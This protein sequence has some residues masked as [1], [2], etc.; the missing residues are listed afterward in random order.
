M[1]VTKRYRLYFY[2]KLPTMFCHC[3]KCVNEWN[4]VGWKISFNSFL[5]YTVIN[6][7][8]EVIWV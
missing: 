8:E 1:F 6:V 2:N 4:N 3:K 7:K 5:V